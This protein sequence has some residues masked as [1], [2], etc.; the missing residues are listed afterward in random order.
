MTTPAEDVPQLVINDD[1]SISTKYRPVATLNEE[2]T[3]AIKKVL[4]IRDVNKP[5]RWKRCLLRVVPS[6]LLALLRVPTPTPAPVT[7]APP[8]H[9]HAGEP[10]VHAGERAPN[11]TRADR[12]IF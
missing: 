4:G 2:K 7:P 9:V 8:P 1:G 10:H 12:V 3:S 11:A 6:R 5:P